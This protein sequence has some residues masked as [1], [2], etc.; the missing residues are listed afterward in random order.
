M[1]VIP[2]DG[3]GF[4]DLNVLENMLDDNVLVVSVMA[5]N[6]KW[7]PFKT[8]PVSP[9]CLPVAAFCFTATLRRH[10]PPWT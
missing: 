10:L 3:K 5:V 2:V 7:A 8:F 6:M 1:E 9:V 4:V